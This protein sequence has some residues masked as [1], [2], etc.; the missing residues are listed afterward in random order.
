MSLRRFTFGDD[1]GRPEEARRAAAERADAAERAAADTAEREG[2]ARGVEAGRRE[3]E[4]ASARRMAEAAERLAS[5]IAAA[6]DRIDRRADAIERDAI[7]FFDALARKLAGQAVAGQPLGAVQEAAA[8]AFRHLR[9]VPHLAVRVNEALVDDVETLLRA[10]ARERGFEGRVIV[11]GE[12]DVPA[13]DARIDW[14]DG[15]VSGE[16]R[17]IEAAVDAVLARTGLT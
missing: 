1:L 4:E 10:M 5:G 2:F 9:G 15:G 12:P 13:G 17:R 14:A 3:A 8:E 16:R 7:D 11:L 6:L